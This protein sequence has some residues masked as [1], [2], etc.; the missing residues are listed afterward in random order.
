MGLA[1]HLTPSPAEFHLGFLVPTVRST[2]YSPEQ[3]LEYHHLYTSTQQ[4][5]WAAGKGPCLELHAV[6]GMEMLTISCRLRNSLWLW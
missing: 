1:V 5:F 6:Q 2:R 4:S 3:I